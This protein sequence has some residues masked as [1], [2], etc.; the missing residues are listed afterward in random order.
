MDFTLHDALMEVF[1]ESDTIWGKGL[2]KIYDNFANDFLYSDINNIL[3][4]LEN[5]DTPRF[6]ALYPDIADYKL[7]LTLLATARGIPQIYYG[8]EIG[9]TGSKAVGD[10]D[11]RRDF[12]GG[13]KADSNNAFTQNGRTQLQNDYHDFTKKVFNW[14]RHKPV[15]H[16]GKTMQFAPQQDVYVYFRYNDSEQIMVVLNN[17]HQERAIDLSRFEE[18]LKGLN[19]AKDMLTGEVLNL[20]QEMTIGPKSSLILEF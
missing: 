13:W 4:F 11:I 7:A 9:M 12:P 8:S 14:R 2:V 15:V 5:H 3:I 19:I 1:N 17:S 6:N 16:F 18:R 10:G 20:D